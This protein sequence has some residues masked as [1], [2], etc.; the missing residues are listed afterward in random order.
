MRPVLHLHDAGGLQNASTRVQVRVHLHLLRVDGW[1]ND[2][3]G[4]APQ[5][6]VLG[7]V[8]EDGVLVLHQGVHDHGA[9][10]QDLV[11]HVPGASG[12]AA[13]V[14]EDHH[15][16]VLAPV[17]VPEGL[18][19]FEGAVGEPHLAAHGLLDLA[20]L[21]VGGVRGDEA[22]D[23]ARLHGDDAHGDAAQAGASADHGAAP[24]LQVLRP[25][26][27][28]KEAPQPPAL[29][30]HHALQ[31]V[32]RVVG[33][34]RRLELHVAVPG[35]A[36]QSA[37][38]R[39]AA[40]VLG[41]E[42]QPV[43]DGPHALLV[44]PHHLVS[45]TVGHHDLRPTQLVLGRVN[46]LTQE[47]V[48]GRVA[49]E[50]HGA[51]HHL[52]VA[53]AQ[54]VQVSTDAHGPACDVGEGK[55]VLV[56]A[57]R[58]A[59]NEAAALQVL[60]ANP[61]FRALH[62]LSDDGVKHVALLP[63]LLDLVRL[64]GARRQL[65]I[66]LLEQVEV[67]EAFVAVFGIQ[68]LHLVEGLQLL[69]QSH[70][71]T[72][73]AGHI[74]AGNA[75][76]AR[77]L[78]R[79]LEELVL[80]HAEGARLEG[81]VVGNDNDVPASWVLRRLHCET[82]GQHA[83]I[84]AALRSLRF[85]QLHLGPVHDQLLGR[86]DV[87]GHALGHRSCRAARRRRP[88]P[89]A[90]RRASGRCAG[91]GRDP[92]HGQR[93]LQHARQVVGVGGARAACRHALRLQ[94][95]Q[96]RLVGRRGSGGAVRRLV[97]QRV[98]RHRVR[99]L[100]Q[101]LGL[102][103]PAVQ[104]A[105]G[106]PQDLQATLGAVVHLHLDLVNTQFDDLGAAVAHV[107]A[108]T[109]GEQLLDLG[110]R[111]VQLAEE[112]HEDAAGHCG[113]K[114]GHARVQHGVLHL[115]QGQVQAFADA[116][117]Q[118]L[119]AH[120]GEVQRAHQKLRGRSLAAQHGLRRQIDLRGGPHFLVDAL[121]RVLALELGELEHAGEGGPH[122]AAQLVLRP[123]L[124]GWV[125]QKLGEAGVA[126]RLREDHADLPDP[127]RLQELRL[128]GKKLLARLGRLLQLCVRVVEQGAVGCGEGVSARHNVQEVQG[129][130]RLRI[131]CIHGQLLQLLHVGLQLLEVL[132][133][134]Q[135]P[136]S[137]VHLLLHG[138]ELRPQRRLAI[139]LQPAE[140]RGCAEPAE[141][142]P[143]ATAL[144]AIIE[145]IHQ[146]LHFQR[147]VH[148]PRQLACVQLVQLVQLGQ[149]LPKV[150]G[151]LL[152][153]LLG[154][155]VQQLL[156]QVPHVAEVP[157]HRCGAGQLSQLD[158]LLVHRA[159]VAAVDVGHVHAGHAGALRRDHLPQD[160]HHHLGALRHLV[161]GHR[162]E[163]HLLQ[164]LLALPD[165]LQQQLVVGLLLLDRLRKGPLV[166]EVLLQKTLHALGSLLAV[167]KGLK[168]GLHQL[169][170]LPVHAVAVQQCLQILLGR[171][172]NRVR[173]HGEL[174]LEGQDLLHLG[175]ILQLQLCQEL[176]GRHDAAGGQRVPNLAGLRGLQ[177]HDHLHGLKLHKGLALGHF[178]A[179]LVQVP[180]HLA[181]HVRAQLAGVVD[182]G[183]HHRLGANDETQ[184][185]RLLLALHLLRD[186]ARAHV[187]RAVRLLAHLGADGA[188]VDSQAE[189][190]PPRARHLEGELLLVEGDI[191]RERHQRVRVALAQQHQLALL[192]GAQR[193]LAPGLAAAEGAEDRGVED[194]LHGAQRRS[195]GLGGD[196]PVQPHGVDGVL[197]VLLGLNE[198]H[199]VIH[200]VPD[201][202]GDVQVHQGEAQALPG[203]L[204][205]R[206]LGKDVPELGVRKL[207]DASLEAHAEVAPA[208]A[209]GLEA[210]AVDLAAG[211]LEALVRVLR[212]DPRGAAV[213]G[214]G[215]VVHREEVDLGV[216]ARVHAV[217]APD[218]RDVVQRH[219]HGDLQLRRRH[220][221]PRDGLRHRVLHLEP[222][223]QL[224][225]A[226]GVGLR[227]VQVLHGA[228]A[229]VA[230]QRGE[231]HGGALHLVEDVLLGDGRRTLLEDLLEP[232]LGRAVAAVQRQGVTILVPQDLDLQVPRL[233]DHLHEENG[234][235]DH[236]CR[237]VGVGH[238]E[239][240][241]VGGLADALSAAA[242]RGLDHDGEADTLGPPAGIFRTG[243]HGLVEDVLRHLAFFGELAGQAVAA[244]GDARHLGRLRQNVRRDLVA[245]GGHDAAGGPD[246][247][248]AN[249]LELGR[250]LG[251]LARMAPAR[252]HCVHLL[253]LRNAADQVHVGVVVDVLPGGD[254]HKR[255][256]QSDELR[257]G[258][259]VVL[260]G[261]GHK[262]DDL[263]GAEL[264]EGPASHG[265]NRL[266]GGHAI[267]G[268]QDLADHTLALPLLDVGR[269][270]IKI[271]GSRLAKNKAPESF[272]H[273][274]RAKRNQHVSASDWLS[275]DPVA[276]PAEALGP[277]GSRA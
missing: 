203:R 20:G 99:D 116:L 240:L 158:D 260:R 85:H 32:P 16:Q 107:A 138:E 10:L 27:R 89:R 30:V 60:D 144:L 141:V 189:H 248:D 92:L 214:D 93:H 182:G 267:V 80:L 149:L 86:Q 170:A 55:S 122:V 217:E 50:D 168:H 94:P 139:D 172:C 37:H 171:R 153:G 64:H 199:Q 63:S 75:S 242:L 82:P 95:R 18:C 35:V 177:G 192:H 12:E 276:Q 179:L 244:P 128:A 117:A 77:Q 219:A 22:L 48:Q 25:G 124:R 257:V 188:P 100:P 194:H 251:V 127:G 38:G 4:A 169:R 81:H 7:D 103:K 129:H 258:V 21:R 213:G 181:V 222:R 24:T 135:Q 187:E 262:S 216:L 209:G 19:G 160:G 275:N 266:H 215:G 264:R 210:D 175:R 173:A 245:Q 249:L 176:T 174:A 91:G 146:E 43:Q 118:G 39:R 17:E 237:D 218:V 115:L 123:L 166:G 185:Q 44:V 154:Q 8:D 208:V 205:V 195:D 256:C 207:V 227:A 87:L 268:D 159:Q 110:H 184:A 46:V 196:E 233:G 220:V 231:A 148:R 198:V 105:E 134:Q 211:G 273:C 180:H 59:G 76:H 72:A 101:H 212:R 142:G 121:Q 190:V 186:L 1:V 90:W 5:L 78:R 96:L 226:E 26:A 104:R 161:V 49:R 11:V 164:A 247:G 97:A 58:L 145:R 183:H 14:G 234:G 132:Q 136:M 261:H 193:F 69:H 157:G 120:L 229:P 33:Q 36:A 61:A 165:E 250:Q 45:H 6:A 106:Q 246:E 52:D 255:V 79:L 163:E 51:A 73:V 88:P 263:L 152:V 28:I 126:R 41:H 277:R 271:H 114:L 9:E 102:Q 272:E 74:N 202:S 111:H 221:H 243:H 224:Q 83:H 232:A 68:P 125:Q 40:G 56:G 119:L 228:R 71:G 84:V 230:H 151:A 206:S 241:H 274:N 133:D 65:L 140:L 53:L 143:Q 108:D 197:L 265:E 13:P 270:R 236:F 57:A 23:G 2:H 253:L 201:V 54:P 204:S 29:D 178:G 191:Q 130:L 137:L 269:Q 239:L 66:V 67:L 254:L 3:P 15:R 131:F 235:A 62:A 259:E 167:G 155:H 42:A 150:R 109:V 70:A 147:S 223:V 47:L 34:R 252:P 98:A 162:H 238:L 31:E 156:R 200:G 113:P 225:E 112:V